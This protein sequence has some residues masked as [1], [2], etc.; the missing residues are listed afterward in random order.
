MIK[1]SKPLP[2]LE[3]K[4]KPEIAGMVKLSDD[5]LQVLSLITAFDGTERRLLVCSPTGILQVASARVE[6]ILNI[7]SNATNY[8]WQGTDIKTSEVLIKAHP[9]N[10]GRVWVNVDTAASDNTGY[11]LNS[12]DFVRFTINNLNNLHLL[13]AVDTEKAII[14]YT[15]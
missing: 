7:L 1:V 13:I 8:T 5:M 15:R 14:I 11:P 3:L 9:D 12:G 2:F 4:G 6:A 10:S